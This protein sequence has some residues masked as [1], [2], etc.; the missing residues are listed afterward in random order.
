LEY[1]IAVAELSQK[2]GFD[3]KQ[4]EAYAKRLKDNLA[5]SMKEAGFSEKQLEKSALAAA[6]AN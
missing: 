3:A 4:T 5:S 2:H 1:S 6:I